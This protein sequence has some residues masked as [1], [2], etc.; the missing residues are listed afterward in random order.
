MFLGGKAPGLL[1][2]IVVIFVPSLSH[3]HKN[4]SHG[5]KWSKSWRV[6][7]IYISYGYSFP[8]NH[9]IILSV[10][11][12]D[13]FHFLASYWS[14]RKNI[15]I[16]RG[17]CMTQLWSPEAPQKKHSTQKTQELLNGRESIFWRKNIL[18]LI[19]L[20]KIHAQMYWRNILALGPIGSLEMGIY[21][22][23]DK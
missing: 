1:Q 18:N 23:C 10:P 17:K 13:N 3:I 16:I 2:V 8:L 11:K 14:K 12:Q 7:A 19:C 9:K 4:L 20:L 5:L 6:G 15:P 21:L 22:L